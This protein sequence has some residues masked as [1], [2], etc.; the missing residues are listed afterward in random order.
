MP[1][2]AGYCSSQCS[3]SASLVD[4]FGTLLNG[5]TLLPFDVHAEGLA[6]LA[7]WL[8]EEAVTIYHSTTSI[9]RHFA[10]TLTEAETFPALRLLYM[11]SEPLIARDI[12]LYK[13]HFPPTCV[14]VHSLGINETGV[15]A[16]IFHG[17]D[18]SAIWRAGPGW[19]RHAGEGP[20]LAR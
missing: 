4:I 3:F 12:A 19:L 6:R 17:P 16:A 10:A 7:A 20:P 14:L 9:F 13:A 11:G 2:T 1:K 8:T 15:R 5:A 18:H